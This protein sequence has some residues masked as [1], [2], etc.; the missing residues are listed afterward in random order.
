MTNLKIRKLPDYA[1]IARE[2]RFVLQ[3]RKTFLCGL[4]VAEVWRV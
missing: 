4:L 2:F 3:E 1:A